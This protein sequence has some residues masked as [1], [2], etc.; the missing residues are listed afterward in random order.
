METIIT[1]I[2]TITIII[3]LIITDI[4][5]NIIAFRWPRPTRDYDETDADTRIAALGYK[6]IQK[7]D[8]ADAL[9]YKNVIKGNTVV[10]VWHDDPDG[11]LTCGLDSFSTSS[12]KSMRFSLPEWSAFATKVYEM[13]K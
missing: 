13:T 4:T 5:I 9:V 6:R 7:F 1:I 10:I 8:K 3:L 11:G 12:G 2:Y